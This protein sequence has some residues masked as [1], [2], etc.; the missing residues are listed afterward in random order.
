MTLKYNFMIWKF[1]F[2][3][4]VKFRNKKINKHYN[5]L[6]STEEWS[7]KELE[8]RQLYLL[9]KLLSYAY[10]N[11]RFYKKKLDEVNMNVDSIN[12]LGDLKQI[13]VLTK[14][15]LKE[16]SKQHQIRDKSLGPYFKSE[17]SGSTGI[18]LLF[19]RNSDWDASHRAAIFRGYSWYGVKPWEQNGYFWGFNFNYVN[20]IKTKVLD[21]L[22]NRFRV[23]SYSDHEI[24]RFVSKLKN[25]NYIEGY[26]SMIYEVARIINKKGIKLKNEIKLIKGTSETIFEN[27]HE[28]SLKAF[29]KKITSE[30]GAAEAGIIAFECPKGSMHI[31]MENVI[32]EVLDY[33]ILVTNL[34]SYSFP[35]IRYELGDYIK[36]N[37]QIKCKCGMNHH[38]IEDVIGRVGSVIKGIKNNYPSLVLYYVAKNLILNH[39]I[40]INYQAIQSIQGELLFQIEKILNKKDEKTLLNEFYKYFKDD[41]IVEIKTGV[42]FNI[43]GKK[44][45]DFISEL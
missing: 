11:S 13:P 14:E 28:E 34:H 31:S 43:E 41:V 1:I 9:K 30:Y 21:L 7:I 44:R 27:Y 16:F 36:V 12:S 18:P 25:A 23:F 19:W 8:D 32:V 3:L 24:D 10:N 42:K 37:K 29:G 17:T 15:E 35:I 38:V 22:Q 6:K 2:Q 4:G 40:K 5:F 45:K 26:S 20:R 39:N 33:K